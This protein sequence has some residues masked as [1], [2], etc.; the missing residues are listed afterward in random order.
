MAA[1]TTALATL[2]LAILASAAAGPAP[3][4]G[5]G[6]GAP[7]DPL[8]QLQWSLTKVGAPGAW[9]TSTGKGVLIGIVDTGTDPN[10]EDLAGKVVAS[11]DCVG[12][13]GQEVACT[14]SA[15]DDNGHGTHVAGIASA[16]ADNGRGIA[17]MA[18]DAKLVV[19]K[20]LDSSGSGNFN[21]VNAGI[22]WVVDHGARVVNLSLGSDM[23]ALSGILGNSLSSGVSYAWSHGAIPVLAAGNQ[24][25]FGLGSSNYGNANAVVVGATGPNDEVAPYSSPLGNAKWALVAPGGDGQDSSGQP[26]CAG[27]AQAN[28][29]VSTWWDSTNSTNAYAFDEGTS[30]AT[31][32]VSGVLALLLAKGL[33]PTA[34]VNTL[35]STADHRVSCGTTCAGRLD[36]AKAVGVTTHQ[37]SPTPAGQ[38]TPSTAPARSP[39]ATPSPAAISSVGS[40]PSSGG[41]GPGGEAAHP[42]GAA[43]LASGTRGSVAPG[44]TQPR[45]QPS[46]GSSGPP[47]EAAPAAAAAIGAS[48]WFFYR[49]RRTVTT[50]P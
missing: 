16:I 15:N 17:G 24:N 11:T 10:Q 22:E 6:P 8:F 48:G 3:A 49:R 34:A 21:D 27:S 33:S 26:S 4:W 12:S 23:P 19:A 13:Q 46:S 14:G 44:T 20:V 32:L 5:L 7:N 1:A 36:A 30:M 35:L 37:A 39:Q 42:T 31:P 29:I 2:T 41:P 50:L 9:T 38:T 45:S 43:A 25:F 28:C 47:W 40:A 18:P